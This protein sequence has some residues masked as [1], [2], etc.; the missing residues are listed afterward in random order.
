[1][2]ARNDNASSWNA[3]SGK[4]LATARSSEELLAPL[5]ELALLDQETDA[6]VSVVWRD[7]W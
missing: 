3:S 5:S 4:C 2:H 6:D 1:M 7:N